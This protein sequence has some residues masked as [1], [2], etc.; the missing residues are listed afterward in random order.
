MQ[1]NDSLE[2]YFAGYNQWQNELLNAESGLHAFLPDFIFIYLDA[3]EFH[4][5]VSDL[6]TSIAVYSEKNKSTSFIVSNFSYPPY[7]VL[8]YS[9]K[10]AFYEAELNYSV[11]SFASKNNSVFIFDFNRLINLYGYQTLFEDKF[12]YLGRI[13]HSRQGF[14]ILAQE[15]NHVLSCLLGQTKK[16]LIVDV[17]N[18]LWG[19]VVGEEGWQHIQ[20][21]QEGI[22]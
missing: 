1:K 2:L 6:F 12:W 20:L 18:T 17:D 22:G 16:V 8:T 11:N 4:S 3:E 14:I 15:L 5:D 21:S 13:K 10:D 19:G 9:S 7:S